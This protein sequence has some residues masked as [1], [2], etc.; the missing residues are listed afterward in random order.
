M[1]AVFKCYPST[2]WYSVHQATNCA[3]LSTLF[4]FPNFSSILSLEL[5]VSQAT[6]ASLKTLFIS[7]ILSPI[8]PSSWTLLCSWVPI[9]HWKQCPAFLPL[10]NLSLI[11]L[12]GDIR[13]LTGHSQIRWSLEAHREQRPAKHLSCG[14]Y[15][16]GPYDIL[17]T[18][19]NRT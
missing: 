19:L 1:R 10:L 9:P 16:L 8:H 11:Q 4:A 2:S 12:W 18:F 7:Q 13:L 17:S 14:C 3:V 15:H 5:S 6:T